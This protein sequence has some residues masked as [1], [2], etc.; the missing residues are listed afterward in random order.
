MM[1]QLTTCK[2]CT[3]LQ[4]N[5][6]FT[7]PVEPEGNQFAKLIFIGTSPGRY[8]NKS[9]AML[10]GPGGRFLKQTLETYRVSF[11]DL[12]FTNL[13]KCY[14]PDAIL[15]A[16]TLT[17]CPQLWLRQ[18]FELWQTLPTIVT[19]GA[20]TLQFFDPTARLSDVRGRILDMEFEWPK[21]TA[22]DLLTIIP[23]Y[24]P[25]IGYHLPEKIQEFIIDIELALATAGLLIQE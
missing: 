2:T 11:S 6:H 19:L 20:E 17:E 24:A 8:E 10:K 9:H 12:Y 22:Y 25:N 3:F 15:R 23:T 16:K 5:S 4:R 14:D 7:G 1:S 13:A 18:E 21:T